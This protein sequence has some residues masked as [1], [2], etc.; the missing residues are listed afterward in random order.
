MAV[1]EYARSPVDSMI[2]IYM[3]SVYD[4][5]FFLNVPAFYSPLTYIIL[6]WSYL[7]LYI[8]Y[9]GSGFVRK[10]RKPG[11]ARM[12]TSEHWER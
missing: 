10:T 3:K 8:W 5:V 7:L 2:K 11:R 1:V 12:G 4:H 6:Q 9:G